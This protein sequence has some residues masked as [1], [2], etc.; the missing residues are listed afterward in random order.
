MSGS[1]DDTRCPTTLNGTTFEGSNDQALWRCLTCA[2]GR[3]AQTT[4]DGRYLVFTTYAK[5]LT[6][7][8]EAD[9]NE[10]QQVYRYDFETGELARISI[11]EPSFPASNNGNAPGM[12]AKITGLRAE[13]DPG[14]GVGALADV[15]DWARAIS[16]SGATIV[17]ST[18][19]R[20][21]ADDTNTGT[22]NVYVWHE[23]AGRACP[24]GMQGEVGVIRPA[25]T[26]R[27]KTRSVESQRC[28]RPARIFS[29]SPPPS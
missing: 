29:S 4:A 28:P 9:T 1:V 18:P 6:A 10:A 25:T 16:E 3:M 19:E 20:L 5:L 8:P 22:N 12:A 17:F 2:S 26:R 14:Y 15:N 11:G 24:D 7:G 23:C 13:S 27:A 21:Q